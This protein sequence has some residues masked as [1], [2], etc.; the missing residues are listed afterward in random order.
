MKDTLTIAEVAKLTNRSRQTIRNQATEGRLKDYV[1]EGTS[2]LKLRREVLQVLLSPA[3]NLTTHDNPIDNLTDNAID[4]LTTQKTT[5]GEKIDNL[6]T[7]K[8]TEK[9]TSDNAAD[10]PID[11]P[12]TP[13][14]PPET[15]VIMTLNAVIAD[16]R[17]QV[18][19]LSRQLE[20]ERRHSRELSDK[21]TAIADHAQ[22]LQLQQMQ[23][24]QLTDNQSRK[25]W[26]KFW[27]R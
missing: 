4:N 21:I 19:D 3:D 11:N 23:L 9:T 13:P 14:E 20:D 18:K 6:L 7:E 2:P 25:P 27:S 24:P 15:A 8:A 1:V 5:D 16:L 12:E 22:Q 26:W 17:E 10:N